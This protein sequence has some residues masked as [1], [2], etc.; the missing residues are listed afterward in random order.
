MYKPV[1]KYDKIKLQSEEEQ[2]YILDHSKGRPFDDILRY[3]AIPFFEIILNTGASLLY[4]DPAPSHHIA[5][6]EDERIIDVYFIDDGSVALWLTLMYNGKGYDWRPVLCEDDRVEDMQTL[7]MMASLLYA[8]VQNIFLY[9]PEAIVSE[10]H[11]VH[12]T[13]AVKK[14]GKYKEVKYTRIVKYYSLESEEVRRHF[15]K[16]DCWGVAGHWRHYKSGKKVFIS[17]Y[18]KGIN[19]DKKEPSN[20]TYL[21]GR[22]FNHE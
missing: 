2:K 5:D 7:A 6:T 20:K 11:E 12:D 13:K 4:T 18:K 14:N 10:D 8:G 21:L 22:I 19:R 16:C 9:R 15:I 1:K 17:P 3:A